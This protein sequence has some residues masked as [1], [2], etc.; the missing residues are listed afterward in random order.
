LLSSTKSTQHLVDKKKFKYIGE[1]SNLSYDKLETK[2]SF[3]KKN[4]CQN[5]TTFLIEEIL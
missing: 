2:K 3:E 1:V 5:K 4:T